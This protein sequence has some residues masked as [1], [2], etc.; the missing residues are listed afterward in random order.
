MSKIQIV[1][2]DSGWVL[3]GESN[4]QAKQVILTNASVV[5][6]WG[7]NKGLGQIALDGPTSG[8]VLDKIG[9]VYIERSQIK[10]LVDCDDKKW[11]GKL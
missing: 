7:T 4:T 3:V 10:F 6:V 8:T 9:V 1:V 11:S 5:R 2:V